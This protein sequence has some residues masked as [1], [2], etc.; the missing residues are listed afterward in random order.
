LEWLAEVVV[1]VV[2]ATIKILVQQV[3]AVAVY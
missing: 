1:V 3:E 2:R